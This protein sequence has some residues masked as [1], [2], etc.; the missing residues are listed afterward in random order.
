MILEGV[1][2]TR[3]QFGFSQVPFC[4]DCWE[5]EKLSDMHLDLATPFEWI[6]EIPKNSV[7]VLN[8]RL[9]PLEESK[10]VSIMEAS[11]FPTKYIVDRTFYAVKER[12]NG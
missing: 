1:V 2:R 3:F 11:F 5:A 9:F 4:F 10:K 12:R 8:N 7:L 6:R